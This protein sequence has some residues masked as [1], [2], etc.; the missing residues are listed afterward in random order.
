MT[1]TNEICWLP[2]IIPC[3]NLARRPEYED[4]LYKIFRA[5]FIDSYPYLFN[6]KVKIRFHPK[7]QNREEAFY[8][9]T[10]K[11]YSTDS[12]ER[13]PDLRRSE[14]IS[15]VRAFMENHNCRKNECLPDCSGIKLWKEPWKSTY[16]IHIMLEEEKYVVVAEEREEY[17]LLITGYY[18]D[19][20]HSLRKLRQRYERYS[21]Q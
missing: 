1:E 5:D 17:C 15:W 16:R 9:V 6:K 4:L 21:R 2:P 12:T 8:H 19:Y 18:I 14:R 13:E 3:E 10:C 11:N 7:F 20:E